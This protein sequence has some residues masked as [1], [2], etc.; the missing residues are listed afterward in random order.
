MSHDQIFGYAVIAG[1]MAYMPIQAAC[2]RIY[3]WWHRNEIELAKYR[4]PGSR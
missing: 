4:H 2:T 3:R 1:A